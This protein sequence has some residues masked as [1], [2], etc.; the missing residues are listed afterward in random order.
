MRYVLTLLFF[1]AL[2]IPTSA[3]DDFLAKQYFNDGDFEKAVIFYEKLVKNHPRRTDYAEGLVA[4][5]QQLER[6]SDVEEFLF[7]QI[8]QGAA[9]PTFY[10]ELGYNYMLQGHAGQASTYYEKALKKIEENSNYGYG[11]GYRFQKYALLDY[12]LKAYAKAMALNPKLDYNYQMA[13]I[14]GEQ[15]NIEKMYSAYLNL[16]GK[17]KTSK[18]NILRSIDDFISS[19]P[20]NDNNIKL[21]KILLQN[22]QKNPDLLWNEL[23]SWLFVKQKQ[24]QSAFRQE[25]AIHKRAE[26]ASLQRLETLGKTALQDNETETATEIFTYI[27]DNTTNAIVALNAKLHLIDIQLRQQDKK[28]LDRVEKQYRELMD[29]YGYQSKTLQLQ[30]AYANFLTFEK[31]NPQ[32]AV[33]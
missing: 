12:A 30:V 10:I 26:N 27:V 13:R 31:E 7:S 23:L 25:K 28:T 5:Y 16:L 15:G 17:G 20:G 3:Q 8:R 18:S 29:T 4:C 22:A 1:L 33:A 2:P 11:V 14:Y 6:Y 21:K 24:Y 9:Y 32:A 19:D